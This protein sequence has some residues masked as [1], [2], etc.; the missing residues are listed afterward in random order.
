MFDWKINLGQAV[1]AGTT[2]LVALIALFQNPVR[3]WHNRP[4]LKLEFKSEEP[5]RQ[6]FASGYDWWVAYRVAVVNKGRG[7][8]E[9]V[10]V[11]ISNVE[12]SSDD[13]QGWRDLTPF[14]P[15]ELLWTHVETSVRDSVPAGYYLFVNFF[16]AY[17]TMNNRSV[18]FQNH[19]RVAGDDLGLEFST[20][21]SPRNA[22][23]VVGPG[24]YRVH[25]T[26]TGNN[27]K[28]FTRKCVLIARP[29]MER[30]GTPS[31][32][33]HLIQDDPVDVHFE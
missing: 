29:I 30:I 8:A 26:V 1:A 22:Y 4:R 31:A 3:K 13:R 28:T 21:I 6:N 7:G 5:Y 12:I 27:V 33:G 11:F 14:V 18:W 32:T 19:Q 15:T 16:N 9:N 24:T 23:N 17:Y 10:R 25:L 2:F 20:M